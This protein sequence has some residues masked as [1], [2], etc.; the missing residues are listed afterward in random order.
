[1]KPANSRQP[2]TRPAIAAYGDSLMEGWGLAS[3]G[4][5]LPAQLEAE[6][7]RL[8]RDV[9]VLNFGVSGETAPEG[10]ERLEEVLAAGPVAAILE[11]GAND[12]YQGVPVEETRAA[13]QAMIAGLKGAG[14]RILLAGWRTTEDLFSRY[15][16]DPDL[17]GLLPLAP[18]A[19][20]AQYV[21]AFNAMHAELAQEHGLALI[22][23]ILAPLGDDARHFQADAVHPNA[24]GTQKL[25]EAFAPLLLPLVP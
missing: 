13:L 6:L 25:A 9:R 24:R 16:D 11:F 14:V 18:P 23:H 7:T 1:M 19:F 8:G 20:D 22:P 17:A 12:C 3:A 15:E 21:R 5:T 10:L 4:E 2:D